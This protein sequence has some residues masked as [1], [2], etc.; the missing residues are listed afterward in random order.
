MFPN[1]DGYALGSIEGRVAIQYVILIASHL[2]PSLFEVH[3]GTPRT[4][5][6]LTFLWVEQPNTRNLDDKDQE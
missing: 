4:N 1:A 2:F 5:S 6:L 3:F